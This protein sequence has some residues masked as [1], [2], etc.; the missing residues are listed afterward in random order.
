MSNQLKRA[1]LFYL[2]SLADSGSPNKRFWGYVKSLSGSPSIPDTIQYNDTSA[3]NLQDMANLFS[4]FFAEC[5]NPNNV[6]VSENRA[7]GMYPQSGKLSNSKC[8]AE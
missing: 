1:K 2:S 4:Q 8:S 6:D 7:S 5:F 3:D